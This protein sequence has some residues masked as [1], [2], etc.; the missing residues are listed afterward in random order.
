MNGLA[1]WRLERILLDRSRGV[2]DCGNGGMLYRQLAGASKGRI[3]F[4]SKDAAG[5]RVKNSESH[6]ERREEGKKITMAF[7]LFGHLLVSFVRACA[8]SSARS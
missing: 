5:G 1:D 8:R 7:L 4:P 3:P 2:V 6:R